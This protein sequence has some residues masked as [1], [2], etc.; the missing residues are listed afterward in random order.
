[1]LFS[2][3]DGVGRARKIGG[4]LAAF[5]WSVGRIEDPWLRHSDVDSLVADDYF[6][7]HG[8]TQ[9]CVIENFSHHCESHRKPAVAVYDAWLRHYA[10]GLAH[11]R[12]PYAYVS[13]GSCITVHAATYIAAHGF[14]IRL[15]GEDF[16][17]LN[18]ATKI[19]GWHA[20]AHRPIV[21]EDRVSLRVPFGTGPSIEKM[22]QLPDPAEEKR[23]YDPRC[24]EELGQVVAA[25]DAADTEML[26]RLICEVLG[27]TEL[28]AWHRTIVAISNNVTSEEG[29]RLALHRNF[30]ALRSLQWIHR[31]SAERYPRIS[32]NEWLTRRSSLVMC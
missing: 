10:E 2:P 23:F 25:I 15:A 6:T 28:E 26:Q 31:L 20:S 9:G 3:R 18:K 24:F 29:M 22:M 13:L 11:A 17:F 16:H 19:G 14:P 7:E 4:D 32:Y 5:L 30:D 12:S 21:I 27:S 8:V 1:M